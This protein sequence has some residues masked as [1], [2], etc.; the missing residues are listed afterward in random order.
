MLSSATNCA[1]TFKRKKKYGLGSTFK[2]ANRQSVEKCPY[3]PRSQ[4]CRTD[5]DIPTACIIFS[6]N[7]NLFPSRHKFREQ[8]FWV[9]S[10][11]KEFS[12][13]S[14]FGNLERHFALKDYLWLNMLFIW[15]DTWVGVYSRWHLCHNHW[16]TAVMW[17]KIKNTLLNLS[18]D[19]Q[20]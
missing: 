19:S 18:W 7:L 6:K 17:A 20:W 12:R 4:S 1:L 14:L 8:R 2:I 5:R 3:R 15:L 10:R 13:R 16:K 11:Y 9:S